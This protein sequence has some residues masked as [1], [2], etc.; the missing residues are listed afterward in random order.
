[1]SSQ[2]HREIRRL[3]SKF[4]DGVATEREAI[5]LAE[6]LDCDEALQ[7]AVVIFMQREAAL[8][9]LHCRDLLA[10]AL[11]LEDI[12]SMSPGE[13]IAAGAV[14]AADRQP[15][16]VQHS[17][18]GAVSAMKNFCRTL[19]TKLE[20]Q[21]LVWAVAASLMLAI[22]TFFLWP[23]SHASLLAVDNVLWS[24]GEDYQSGDRLGSDWIEFD[25]GSIQLAFSSSATMKIE[26][27]ARFRAS[28]NG[29]CELQLGSALTY[30]PKAAQG[31]IVETPQM[32]VVDLGTSFRVTVAENS[33]SSVQ[34]LEGVVEAEAKQSGEV[35]ELVAS[36]VA[37]VLEDDSDTIRIISSKRIKPITSKRIRFED[38]HVPSLGINGLKGNNRCFVFLERHD[39]ALPHDLVANQ[40]TT[41]VHTQFSYS[42][43]T[44]PLGTK[45]DCYLIHSAPQVKRHVVEGQII[46]PGKILGVITSSDKLNATND[47]FGSP[48][49][50]KCG[51]PERGLEGVPNV[52]SDRLEISADQRTLRMTMR[53]ES[54]DQLRV[55]VSTSADS[56]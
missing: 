15:K 38:K 33:H 31:F 17:N 1:M 2:E 11:E 47:L 37:T 24:N 49:S 34:V 6:A 22:G 25:S 46:F 16:R 27:P 41:G 19:Q 23:S 8:D 40:T 36:D 21:P 14:L 20:D 56:K 30:V 51:H 32:R 9:E 13:T 54:I 4:V 53:T 26:G 44:I 7:E 5:K 45:V 39:L 3:L 42:G 12:Q 52:N 50:L 29:Y 10:Q 43:G 48:W 18:D 35:R 55:L 28:G